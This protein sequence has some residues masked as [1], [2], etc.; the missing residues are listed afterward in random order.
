MKMTTFTS[1][2]STTIILI[3]C[4]SIINLAI[5]KPKPKDRDD[6]ISKI[7]TQISRDGKINEENNTFLQQIL[8]G[9]GGQCRAVEFTETVKHEECPGQVREV[10]NKICFGQCLS[11]TDPKVEGEKKD[12]EVTKCLPDSISKTMVQFKN[13]A[14]GKVHMK[15]VVMVVS[16]V[17]KTQN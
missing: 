10:R 6:L 3:M 4:I 14:D 2:T 7:A 17:C 16:C 1:S 9:S 11:R 8:K 5:A 13:C 15:E 12:S